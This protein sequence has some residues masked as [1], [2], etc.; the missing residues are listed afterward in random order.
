MVTTGT[1]DKIRLLLAEAQV[2]Y[3]EHNVTGTE[4]ATLKKSLP[5]STLP[6]LEDGDL[7]LFHSNAILRYVADKTGRS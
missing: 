2:P 1:C 6:M 4:F 7:C 5:F 3:I